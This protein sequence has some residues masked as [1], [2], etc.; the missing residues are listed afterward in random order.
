MCVE[1]FDQRG[2]RRLP[3]IIPVNA[4]SVLAP[5]MCYVPRDSSCSSPVIASP[6]NQ[7]VFLILELAE[8]SRFIIVKEDDKETEIAVQLR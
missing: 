5:Y 8:D 3:V 4:L 2:E 1:K 7:R 6:S